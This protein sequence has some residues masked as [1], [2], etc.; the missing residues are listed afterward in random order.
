MT[1][2]YS[3]FGYTP[4]AQGMGSLQDTLGKVTGN[5]KGMQDQFGQY[6]QQMPQ[7]Y[8]LPK[9]ANDMSKIAELATHDYNYN[10][11]QMGQ[12]PQAQVGQTGFQGFYDPEL[13]AKANTQD[14]K[15]LQGQ[16]G[17]LSDLF[18][19]NFKNMLGR[20]DVAKGSYDANV[21]GITDTLGQQ[22]DFMKTLQ[23]AG[24][25]PYQAAQIASEK[26]KGQVVQ[27]GDEQYLVNPY[28]GNKTLLGKSK[29][30]LSQ[31]QQ[32]KIYDL[33]SELQAKQA[34][35]NRAKELLDSGK[36]KTGT[37]TSVRGAV[38]NALG[39]G[40]V[41][42]PE[43]KEF[44]NII[45]RLKS[46]DALKFGGKTLTGPEKEIMKQWIADVDKSP[47]NLSLSL[48]NLNRQVTNKYNNLVKAYGLESPSDVGTD[49]NSY[50]DNYFPPK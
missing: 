49:T 17:W 16:F 24:M 15:A 9:T 50:L 21:K 43:E 5:V 20:Y 36:V 11:Q 44:M 47:Q 12:I 34:D 26:E 39:F 7:E 45:G 40:W 33:S 31:D 13:A 18:N 30:V 29:K 38:S 48:N 6:V 25:T 8:G 46:E 1:D 41:M 27:I 32:M 35:I 4:Q 42:N 23:S 19:T 3:Q 28:T 22:L 2:L 14:N 37:L 10:A